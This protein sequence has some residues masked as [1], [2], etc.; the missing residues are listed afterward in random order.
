MRHSVINEQSRLLA[1][2]Q[3]DPYLQQLWLKMEPIYVTFRL[4]DKQ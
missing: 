2:L 1:I 3:A 4:P